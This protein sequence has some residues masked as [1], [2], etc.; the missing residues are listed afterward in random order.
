MGSTGNHGKFTQVSRPICWYVYAQGVVMIA[1]TP[2]AV[3]AGVQL[4]R[5]R[6]GTA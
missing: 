1:S 6:A 3:F 2:I 5:T 4:G